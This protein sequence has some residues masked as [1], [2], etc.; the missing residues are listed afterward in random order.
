MFCELRAEMNHAETDSA[1][2]F[3]KFQD[4]TQI[5][6][7]INRPKNQNFFLKVDHMDMI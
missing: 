1:V 2:Q 6:L 3:I 7:I 5:L 4:V